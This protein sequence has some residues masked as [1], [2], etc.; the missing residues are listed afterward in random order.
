ARRSSLGTGSDLYLSLHAAPLPI[1]ELE[2]YSLGDAADID[3]LQMAMREN[4]ETAVNSTATDAVRRRVLLDMV[5]NLE[6][7]ASYA[8][9]LAGGLQGLAG[10]QVRTAQAPIYVLG[11]AAGRGL[12]L[13]LGPDSLTSQALPE[14]LAQLI[15]DLLPAASR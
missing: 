7:G 2:L 12:L 3:S 5:S 11:G 8:A 6:L 14:T 15:G 4:A 9:S 13:E 1:D 10:Y